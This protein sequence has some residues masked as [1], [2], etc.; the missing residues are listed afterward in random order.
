V[1]Q[2]FKD[3]AKIGVEFIECAR[4]AGHEDAGIERV[5][6]LVAGFNGYAFN[7]AAYGVEAYQAA[8][9]KHYYPN[10]TLLNWGISGL[11]ARWPHRLEACATGNLTM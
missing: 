6:E 2:K 10:S 1:K 5:R 4:A 7:K 9:Q 3:I 8:W 11:E